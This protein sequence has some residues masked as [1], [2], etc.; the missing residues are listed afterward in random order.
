MRQNQLATRRL[1]QPVTVEYMDGRIGT[2]THATWQKVEIHGENGNRRFTVK[3]LVISGNEGF[4][5]GMQ[6][7]AYANPD[8]DWTTKEIKWRGPVLHCRKAR[9]RI[10]QG[11]IKANEAPDWVKKNHP[12]V[13]QPRTEWPPPHREGL[14][15]EVILKKGFQPRREPTRRN[16]PRDRVAFEL[17][18][19]NELRSGRWRIGNGPQAVQMLWAAKAGGERRPCHDY[20]PLNKWIVDDA[21]PLPRIKDLMTD[22]A[23]CTIITSLDLPRAYNEIR[24]KD[25]RSE[26]LLAFYCGA[27]LY[28][29][30]V[31]QFGS[32]TAVAHF[33][34]CITTFLGDLIGQG[35][36]AYLDNIVIY[37]SSREKHDAL[38]NETLR[39]LWKNHL[40][41]QPKKCEW[42]KQEVQFCGFLVGVQGVRLDPAK[43]AA[44]K[45]WKPPSKERPEP[46]KTQLREFLGFC[47]FY[48]DAVR[49]YSAI[50]APLT[51]LTSKLAPWRWGPA[52]EASFKLLKIAVL[53]APVLAA[54][55]ER[56]PVEVHTDA[57]DRGVAGTVEHR[58]GCGHTQPIAFFSVKTQQTRAELRDARQ[59]TIGNSKNLQVR[60][61]MAPRKPRTN[62]SLD[63][64]RVTQVVP[65]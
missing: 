30:L 26:D 2:V 39:R 46:M 34:R 31:M 60:E 25:K 63:R 6:W 21:F 22:I 9:T 45:E 41:I 64:Q 23:G 53:T 18:G 15:Y 62:K 59:G 42:A 10:I 48:R 56:L 49:D 47:N 65:Q 17:L 1:T 14:D 61:R 43:L 28:A 5:L 36:H 13:L 51:A 19:A 44:V 32:K 58:Y 57:S 52:E 4:T 20:R 55:D 40:T 33:Q 38:L 37:A 11:E 12:E 3:Y 27:K 8:L 7:L 24:I 35:V 50:A 54:Y 29:P 16:T